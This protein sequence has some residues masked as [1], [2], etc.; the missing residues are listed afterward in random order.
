MW[1]ESKADR[2]ASQIRTNLTQTS[3]LTYS[4]TLPPSSPLRVDLL[5]HT[6]TTHRP[7]PIK[8][9]SNIWGIWSWSTL[10]NI[11]M[12]YLLLSLGQQLQRLHSQVAFISEENTDLRAHTARL[13]DELGRYGQYTR[14]RVGSEKT[15]S[16]DN[17][18]YSSY[19]RPNDGLA[20]AEFPWNGYRPERNDHG[21][22]SIGRIVLGGNVWSWQTLIRH[23]T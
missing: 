2:I 5:P 14:E 23:P 6:Q 16:P 17:D 20:G 4:A 22:T 12:L 11:V 1:Q 3:P 9:S 7:H 18:I 10:I 8:P 13:Q 21:E 19:D 15:S